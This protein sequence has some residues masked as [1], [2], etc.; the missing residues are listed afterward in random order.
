MSGHAWS[1]FGQAL[2][3]TTAP[4]KVLQVLLSNDYWQMLPEDSLS[5]APKT[6]PSTPGV[7]VAQAV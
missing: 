6:L 5:S 7:S 4:S 3:A 2:I 1:F